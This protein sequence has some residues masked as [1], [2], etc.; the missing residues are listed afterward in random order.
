MYPFCALCCILHL[1]NS[2]ENAIYYIGHDEKVIADALKEGKVELRI[3]KCLCQGPPRVGKTHLKSLLLKIPIDTCTGMEVIP[4]TPCA[5]QAVCARVVNTEKIGFTGTDWE[6]ID[7]KKML[8]YIAG[9]LKN[10]TGADRD[11]NQSVEQ[12]PTESYDDVQEP[13]QSELKEHRS[14]SIT[15][16]DEL[17]I[18]KDKDLKILIKELKSLMDDPELVEINAQNWIFFID[19]GGQPQFQD[20]LQAFVPRTSVLISVFKLTEK[21]SDHPQMAYVTEDGSTHS[22]GPHTLSNEEIISR[23]SRVYSSSS[24]MTVIT[25]GTYHDEYKAAGSLCETI[26]AKNRALGG[27]LAPLEEQHSVVYRSYFEEYKDYIFPVDGLQAEKKKFDDKIICDLRKSITE[28]TYAYDESIPLRW[29]AFELSIQR[30]A[31]NEKRKILT[32]DECSSISSCL[33]ISKGSLP[34]VLNFLSDLNLI[35]YYEEVLPDIVFT[36]PQALLDIVTELTKKAYELS[37]Q[38]G[39][40][41]RSGDDIKMCRYGIVS[42]GILQNTPKHYMYTPPLFT[43]NELV[44]ILEH[45]KIISRLGNKNDQYFMPSLLCPLKSEE[46]RKD[47]TVLAFHF[48]RGCVPAGLFSALVVHLSS[49]DDWDPYHKS[50]KQQYSNAIKFVDVKKPMKVLLMDCYSHLEIHCDK[51]KYRLQIKNSINNAIK[52]VIDVRKFSDTACARQEAFYC[53]CC[54]STHLATVGEDPGELVCQET[55]ETYKMNSDE[56]S[57]LCCD[58]PICEGSHDICTHMYST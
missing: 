13:E 34:A 16:E 48:K 32:Q 21:L 47:Q 57:W 31:K 29:F 27:I 1:E 40:E 33:G 9:K 51:P 28:A 17:A 8:Q 58:D 39:H 43:A 30:V 53:R 55:L 36:T 10:K 3:T 54:E 35:L 37:T 4:S 5:E 6:I 23:I 44:K 50:I 2:N 42:L 46:L 26:E 11:Q 25:V 7:D 12:S 22:L 52:K 14:S 18:L 24:R 49:L 56:R 19:S 41:I 38:T 15:D 20:I 45:L